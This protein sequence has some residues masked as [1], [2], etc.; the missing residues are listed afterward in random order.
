MGMS[1]KETAYDLNFDDPGHFSKFFKTN[2]GVSP[3][4]YGKI[5]D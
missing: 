2:M 3:S 1:A 4:E 5:H